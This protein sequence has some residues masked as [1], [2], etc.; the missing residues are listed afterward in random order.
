MTRIFKSE[1]KVRFGNCDPAGIV[2]HPQ[3]YYILNFLQEEFLEECLGWAFKKY[4]NRAG[5]PIVGI[6]TE[7]VETATVGDV[8]ESRIWIEKLGTKSVR[9]AMV[10]A[11][12][13]TGS[14]KVKCV[15][16]CV[17]AT[18]TPEIGPADIPESDRRAFELYLRDEHTPELSFRT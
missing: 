3:Y 14:I 4:P 7:F 12:K 2:Y 11:D 1:V 9:F 6:R 5:Y 8:L 13:K 16:T 18:F 17:Y 15:Q 10:L